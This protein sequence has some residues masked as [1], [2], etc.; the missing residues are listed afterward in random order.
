MALN[1]PKAVLFDWDNTL[2][3]TW[4]L[5]HEAMHATFMH[6]GLT[7]WTLGQVQ[8]RVAKS[9]REWFPVLFKDRWEEAA[10]IYQKTY[11][12]INLKKLQVLAGAEATLQHLQQIGVP[13]LVVSNKKG[14]TLRDESAHLGWDD[15]FVSLYGA[16]DAA[17]DK[18]HPALAELAL[19]RLGVAPSADIW[20]VGDSVVDVECA[21]ASGLSAVFFGEIHAPVSNN[22]RLECGGFPVIAHATDHAALLRLL[23]S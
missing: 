8:E 4:P 20:F 16:G 7:P 21:E 3:D 12:S 17:F 11:R 19:K 6:M 18:P 22:G 13:A 1:K 10:G 15:Y 9:M 23:R 5:I 14:P 2:V